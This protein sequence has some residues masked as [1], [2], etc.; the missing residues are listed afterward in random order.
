MDR[1]ITL[2]VMSLKW[3]PFSIPEKCFVFLIRHFTFAI[4]VY[5]VS[6]TASEEVQTN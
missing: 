3:S 1:V 4:D 5:A 6:F 2:L